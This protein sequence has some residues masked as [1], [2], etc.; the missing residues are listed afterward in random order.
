MAGAIAGLLGVAQVSFAAVALLS[1]RRD[2]FGIAER[3]NTAVLRQ[4]LF[5]IA[6]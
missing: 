2:E 4:L 1:V 5:W 6:H 3:A